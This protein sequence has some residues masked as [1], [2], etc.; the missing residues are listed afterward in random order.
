MG[1]ILYVFIVVL[2]AVW[3]VGFYGYQ[4]GGI[5]HLLLIVAVI[6]LIVRLVQ[7]RKI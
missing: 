1:N 2:V 5:I 3:A 7:S 4:A 6:V